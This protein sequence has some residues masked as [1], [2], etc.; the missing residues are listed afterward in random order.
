MAWFAAERHVL[1]AAA[2]NAAD[3]G[4]HS[5]IWQLALTL[6]QFYQRQ[7]YWH[8]W[9]SAMRTALD[10]AL[11]V[12][13]LAAQ[14]HTR[15]G[16]AGAYH[17]LGRDDEALVQLERTHEL[18]TELGYSTE[19]AYLHSNFGAVLA[20]Q[21]HYDRAIEHYWR[22]Y[23]L[24]QTIPHEKGKAAA[25]EGIGRCHGQQ[26]RHQ[27]AISFAEKAMILYRRVGDGNGEGNCWTR[28]GESRHQLGQYRQ[29]MDCHRRA[30]ALCQ[31]LGN[32][33]DEAEGLA[34]LGD[35]SLAAGYPAAAGQ[36]WEK[37]LIILDELRLPLAHSV[38]ARLI[39]LVEQSPEH[40]TCLAGTPTA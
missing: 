13:D 6:Q 15:R 17:F 9:A 29:A 34:S 33:A 35:S 14:A 32:R 4:W 20:S 7:G 5:Y 37:A 26:G 24:Y 21:G 11:A 2:R 19:H 28:L 39:R 8:D 12:D 27:E 1:K 25:L 22:A 30:I 16:L 36:A 3:A 18:F 40:V 38:R 31:E 23:D 10:A